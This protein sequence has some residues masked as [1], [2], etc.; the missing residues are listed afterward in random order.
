MLTTGQIIE[1]IDSSEPL[2]IDGDAVRLQQVFLNLIKNAIT[3]A[4]LSPK[5]EL[6]IRRVDNNRVEI[7]VQDYGPGIKAAYLGEIFSR[8]YQVAHN[9]EYNSGGMGLGLFISQQLVLAHAGTLT[10]KS[11]EGVGTTFIVQLPLLEYQS[12]P[13]AVAEPKKPQAKVVV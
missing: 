12:S 8:F 13:T 9:D 1:L 4:S 11:T 6:S 7:K 3:H 2:L 5:I 10:V